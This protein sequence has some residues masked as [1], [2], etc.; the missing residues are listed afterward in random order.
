MATRDVLLAT[1][2]F[3]EQGWTQ[4]VSARDAKGYPVGATYDGAT[5]FCVV[6]ALERA[7]MGDPMG[8]QRAC[9]AKMYMRIALEERT[10][11]ASAACFCLLGAIA[12][13]MHERSR[14]PDSWRDLVDPILA[15]HIPAVGE[16]AGDGEGPDADDDLAPAA[17]FNDRPNTK[18]SDVLAVLDKAIEWVAK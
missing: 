18:L 3:V 8:Y 17:A 11:N 16:E 10:H 6:G 12:R 4:G 13:E 2:A 14:C 5:Q 9:D 1:K 7:T 15:P